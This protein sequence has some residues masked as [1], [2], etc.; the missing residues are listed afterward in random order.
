MIFIALG[1]NLSGQYSSPEQALK[2]S[3]FALAQAGIAP[4]RISPFYKTAPVGPKGQPDYVNAVASVQTCLAPRGLLHRLHGIEAAFGRKRDIVWGARTLD[5]DLLDYHGQTHHDAPT[6]P[7]PRLAERA[8][9]LRPLA[10]I[11]PGWHH[12]STGRPI[13]Q[14]LAGLTKAQ[15][16]GVGRLH[17]G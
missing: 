7:H 3:L 6:L 13:A 8:F 9:V 11:A 5:L 2:A 1:S 4:H 16:D 15:R 17:V 10:D 14:L 12:P